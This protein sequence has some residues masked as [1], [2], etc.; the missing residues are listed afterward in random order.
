MFNVRFVWRAHTQ[1]FTQASDRSLRNRCGFFL[2]NLIFTKF[3]GLH[4]RYFLNFPF[5]AIFVTCSLLIS[6]DLF[7]RTY[8][9]KT[10]RNSGLH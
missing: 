10:L 5:F 1:F 9:M 7:H 6:E 8:G 4:Q 2:P 3:L